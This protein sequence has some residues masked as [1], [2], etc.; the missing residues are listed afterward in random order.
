MKVASN[1]LTITAFISLFCLPMA[2]TLT[3]APLVAPS[4]LAASTGE[5]CESGDDTVAN[6]RLESA[7]VLTA[8]ANNLAAMNNVLLRWSWCLANLTKEVPHT[9]V[10]EG[11]VSTSRT[12]D[13]NES[14]SQF[15]TDSKNFQQ[16]LVA[17]QEARRAYLQHKLLY[18]QHVATFH[19][20]PQMVQSIQPSNT[21]QSSSNK[22]ATAIWVPPYRSVNTKIEDACAQLI[23]AEGMLRGTETQLAEM[24]NYLKE[25]KAKLPPDEYFE[26]WTAV[27]TMGASVQR[28]VIQYGR[29][30]IAKQKATDVHMQNVEQE[31]NVGG[32][33]RQSRAAL[34]EVQR[35]SNLNNEETQI[36]HLH[37]M[38]ASNALY[39]IGTL[40]PLSPVAAHPTQP[41][42]VAP[43]VTPPIQYISSNEIQNE[44]EALQ[45]E[46]NVMQQKYKEAESANPALRG[47]QSE[48]AK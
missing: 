48:G 32:N 17:Y 29:E 14:A 27:Q 47:A 25:A 4:A 36:A 46:Y 30:C 26:R 28:Q 6:K 42:T 8:E 41:G 19:N 24:I 13:R 18:D 9:D 2:L 38:F 22:V 11:R 3:L 33:E 39:L 43:G 15:K 45:A 21:S 7:H 44:S 31:A 40:S 10:E 23:Q 37:T 1:K 20:Q 16:L 35:C 12:E 5:C 34:I